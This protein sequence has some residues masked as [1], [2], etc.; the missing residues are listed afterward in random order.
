MSHRNE[1]DLE[2]GSSMKS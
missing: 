1:S 2:K